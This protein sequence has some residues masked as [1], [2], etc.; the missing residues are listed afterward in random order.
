M[1]RNCR[2]DE[3]VHDKS[4]RRWIEAADY[5]SRLHEGSR[6]YMLRE[7][8]TDLSGTLDPRATLSVFAGRR[9]SLLTVFEKSTGMGR[10]MVPFFS[11]LE[12]RSE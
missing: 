9:S 10:A 11:Q 6:S 4:Q 8:I 7:S 12:Q 3:T 1:C 2:S 5:Y